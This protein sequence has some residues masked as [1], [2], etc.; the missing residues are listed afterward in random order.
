MPERPA[1]LLVPHR[2][3]GAYELFDLGICP[4]IDFAVW[5]VLKDRG[6]R[7]HLIRGHLCLNFGKSKTDRLGEDLNAELVILGTTYYTMIRST[8]DER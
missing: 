4:M 5:D 7:R 3:I 6:Q 1:V 8:Q 2:P